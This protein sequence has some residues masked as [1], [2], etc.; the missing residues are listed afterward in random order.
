M[1]GWR[2]APMTCSGG[3]VST[4]DLRNVPSGTQFDADLAL[5][6]A[7]P[8]G[9]ALAREFSGARL[10]LL[11]VESGGVDFDPEVQTLNRVENIGDPNARDAMPLQRGYT[12]DLT[13]L[14]DIPAFELRNR[15]VGG[16]T[17]TWVGKCAA[18]DDIDFDARKWVPDSGWPLQRRDLTDALDRAA[19]LLNLG[20]NIYDRALYHRLASPPADIDLNDDLMRTFF[21]QFS[22]RIKGSEPLRFADIARGLTA[23][24]IDILT[25]A[26][27][28]RIGLSENGRRVEALDV[29]SLSG[30]EAV[31]RAPVIVLCGGG[32]ENARMLL[33]SSDVAAKGIGNDHDCVGRY[34]ADH[35]RTVIA[36][37]GKETLQ[38]VAEHFGFYGLSHN[39]RTHFYLRGLALSPRLQAREGLL[40]CATYPVQILAPNDPWLALKRFYSG[41]RR[42]R[43]DDLRTALAA[44][45]G[46]AA[47]LHRRLIMK[48]GLPRQLTEL[49]F[50]AMAEQRPNRDSR[51]TL[52]SLRDQL[53][54]P[55]ARV[56]WKIG[57]AETASVARL[58]ELI[59][60]EFWRVGLPQPK[61]EPWILD[62]DFRNA[63]F[64][65][66]AHPACTTRMG[67]DP[68]TSVVDR[69]ARVHDVEG[70]YVAGSSVFPTAGHANP[71]LMI[72]AMTLRLADHLKSRLLS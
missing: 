28:T 55:L 9:L 13:W 12:G 58:A 5:V 29:K 27:V 23:G 49:R 60:A 67:D 22:H 4:L 43:L 36:R 41:N 63:P 21:W 61:L 52:S 45:G 1:G 16:S 47:G 46:L 37:F 6:G 53:G 39:R 8:A 70:L 14:N 7:G 69:N 19:A 44:P 15:M 30:K 20:P 71:T 72:I 35:P 66:M 26:T 51:V 64:S 65:D 10:K 33:A 42:F 11:L 17:H 38:D 32:I 57:W 48:R 62:E 2:A 54:I 50:D 68:A 34:L 40:N 24:N 3:D 31:I 25:H 59:S 56:D 18:F